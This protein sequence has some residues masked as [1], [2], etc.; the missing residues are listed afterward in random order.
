MIGVPGRVLE[1]LHTRVRPLASKDLPHREWAC[2][3]DHAARPD[4]RPGR[5]YATPDGI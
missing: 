2:P 3:M 4:R 1:A 5:A